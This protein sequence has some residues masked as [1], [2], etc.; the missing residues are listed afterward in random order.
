LHLILQLHEAHELQVAERTDVALEPFGGA[1]RRARPSPR[2]R[3]R[4]PARHPRSS[5]LRWSGITIGV[6]GKVGGR[7]M[8]VPEI[9]TGGPRGG[10][11]ELAG[12]AGRRPARGSA[13]GAGAGLVPVAALSATCGAVKSATAASI[14]TARISQHAHRL[15]TWSRF[16]VRSRRRFLEDANELGIEMLILHAVLEDV[17]RALD[18][19]RLL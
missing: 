17:D 3:E 13:D 6:V 19:D 15:I 7:A 5:P 2:A 10:W 9:D 4:G 11:L 12:A 1:P 16:V 18:R 8:S 14:V